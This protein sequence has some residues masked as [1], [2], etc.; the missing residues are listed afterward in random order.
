MPHYIT[1]PCRHF[2]VIAICHYYADDADIA[3]I[4]DDIVTLTLRY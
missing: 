3:V 1:P 4:D 2:R